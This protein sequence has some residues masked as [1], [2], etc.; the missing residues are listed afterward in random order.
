MYTQRSIDHMYMY[1]MCAINT[2]T[3][4]SR[5]L[6]ACVSVPAQLLTVHGR[7]RE[8]KGGNTGLASW[9]HIAAVK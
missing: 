3:G 6:R 2:L 8:Q 4:T 5:A 1:S 9:E 7:K